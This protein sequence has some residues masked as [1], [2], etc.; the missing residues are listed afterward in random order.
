VLAAPANVAQRVRPSSGLQQK[1]A[2]ATDVLVEDLF[3]LPDGGIGM[4]FLAPIRAPDGATRAGAVLLRVDAR[5]QLFPL[6]ARWPALSRSAEALMLRREGD[7]LVI[8]NDLR[9]HADAALKLRLPLEQPGLLAA[10]VAR[11][12]SSEL[13]DGRDYR[14]VPGLGLARIV[15]DSPWRVIVKIDKTEA[16]APVRA[17]AWRVGLGVGVFLTMGGLLIG[18]FWRK[19][20]RDYERWRW[21]A[22]KERQISEMKSRFI[23]V[24]SHEF[25]TPIT[26]AMG[27]VELLRNHLDR[28]AP[29]KRIA[30]FDRIANALH[31]MTGMLDDLQLLNRIE[32]GRT[33]VKI[34]PVDLQRCVQGIVEEARLIDRDAHRFEFRGEGDASAVATDEQLLHPILSNLLGNAVRYSP[35]ASV[36]TVVL[37]V[38]SSRVY[39]AVED[40]GI[41]VPEADRG[42]IFEAFERGS[43]VGT[44]KGTGLG[45]NIVRRLTEMLGGICRVEAP[46]GQG[47]RFVLEF[48]RSV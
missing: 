7:A 40:Q 20:Q 4:D 41:G 23:T 14:N 8:L 28:L 32:S 13:R 48:P 26:V 35:P 42:R 24:T 2:H 25:R 15:A 34:A 16:Y 1:F 17:D 31:H 43:N 46:A 30:M 38:D 45:L 33:P 19:R 39:L 5:R 21:E 6:I 9:F 29:A 18:G 37:Q 44:S 27:T 10:I 12:V 11:E 3:A 36:V 47:S 22:G